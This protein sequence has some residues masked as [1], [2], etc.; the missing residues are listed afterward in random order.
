MDGLQKASSIVIVS[1]RN[2]GNESRGGG[3]AEYEEEKGGWWQVQ[4]V[5]SSIF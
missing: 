3:V 1:V 2:R 4:N 5:Y